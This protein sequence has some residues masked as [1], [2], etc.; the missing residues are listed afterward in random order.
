MTV[1]ELATSAG[2]ADVCIVGP[3]GS[4][5]VVECKLASN[6]D[7][8][9]MVIGQVID[10]AS[11]IWLDGEKAFREQWARQGGA[12]LDELWEGAQP[13]YC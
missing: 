4:I 1:R 6:S 7:R 2:P 13:K 3:D 9:R 5:T 8:R 11:A 12:E 10:Y